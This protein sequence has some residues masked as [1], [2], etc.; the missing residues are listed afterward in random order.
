MP[1][2]AHRRHANT[3]GNGLGRRV[4]EALERLATAALLWM[5]AYSRADKATARIETA[6]D[7][8]SV[9]VDLDEPI[10]YHDILLSSINRR[11]ATAV[12]LALTFPF[13][14]LCTMLSIAA[15]GYPRLAGELLER[16]ASEYE[17]LGYNRQA[18][19]MRLAAA[20]ARRGPRGPRRRVAAAPSRFKLVIHDRIGGVPVTIEYASPGLVEASADAPGDGV[21]LRYILG[22][23]PPSEAACALHREPCRAIL[24]AAE[25]ATRFL[26]HHAA[27]CESLARAAAVLL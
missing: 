7:A 19:L 4:A 20:V 21:S 12:A 16:A 26:E 6:R 14:V 1:A 18:G 25:E 5:R 17:R 24:E 13:D 2:A 27:L 23:E 22:S 10:T 15:S 8:Q 3:G 11:R 9:L